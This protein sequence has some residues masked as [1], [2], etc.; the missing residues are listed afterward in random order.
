MMIAVEME[1]N[2]QAVITAGSDRAQKAK[3]VFAEAVSSIDLETF[4]APQA[5][6]MLAQ[7]LAIATGETLVAYSL[8]SWSD[9]WLRRKQ[10]DS[11]KSTMSRYSSH[12]RAF[13]DWLGESRSNKPLE[14]VT[15][16]DVRHWRES[17]QDQ[18]L[19]GKTVNS[20]LKDIGSVY[21]AAIRE[22]LITSNPFSALESIDT[23]DSLDRKPFTLQEVHLLIENAP[24]DQWRG[25]ILTA[26][27]TGLRLG[28]AA[29]LG[30]HT[31]DLQT[32]TIQLTPSKTRKKKRVVIIPIQTDLFKLLYARSKGNIEP[33]GPVFPELSKASVGARDGL[34]QTF[35]K[36]MAKAGVDRGKPSRSPSQGEMRGKGRITYERGFHSLRH[37]FTTWLRTAGV[38]EE[39]RMSLTGHSTRDSHQ[40]YSHADMDVLRAAIEKLPSI[41][42]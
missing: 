36:I 29:S 12:V 9:E 28:D 2:A 42:L 40:V 34:S 22:G 17:M 33:S 4:T 3:A 26:A 11:S 20:Y 38:P 39:D 15:S 7:L 13:L 32:K 41:V 5:H 21:R 37:T 8:K 24:S 1:R 25:L 23:S 19:A 30:W 31:V 27:F 14:S 35:N 16:Q 10:R 18:S 6:K